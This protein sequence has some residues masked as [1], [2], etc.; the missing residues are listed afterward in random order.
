MPAWSVSVSLRLLDAF[1][2]LQHTLPEAERALRA[3]RASCVGVAALALPFAYALRLDPHLPVDPMPMRWLMTGGAVALLAASFQPWFLARWSCR[4]NLGL[5]YLLVGYFCVLAWANEF[6]YGFSVGTLF[7]FAAAGLAQGLAYSNLAVYARYL[8]VT[9]GMVLLATACSPDFGTHEAVLGLSTASLAALLY[10]TVQ[11]RVELLGDLAQSESHL[12]EAQEAA[13][14]GSWEMDFQTGQIRGP[15]A[16]TTSR[17]STPGPFPARRPSSRS[18]TRTMP[19]RCP[20]GCASTTRS[21][22]A[23]FRAGSAAWRHAE[24]RRA[25]VHDADGR[26]GRSSAPS[27]TQLTRTRARRR[28]DAARP[29]RGR[30]RRQERVPGQHE[31]RDPHAADGHH[32]L[33]PSCSPSETDRGQRD[34]VDPSWPP[35]GACWRRST[36]SSTSPGWRPAT[37]TSPSSRGLR[38]AEAQ[39]VVQL[40]ALA[41]PRRPRAPRADAR[42]PGG[43]SATRAASA[44]CS[45]TSSPTPSSSPPTGASSRVTVP[46]CA[47]SACDRGARTPGA[48]MARSS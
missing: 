20:S 44:A 48:G 5:S 11:A 16:C 36:P 39:A 8:L 37:A 29:R 33:S 17:A 18:S 42:P 24:I 12:A 2:P 31:P 28:S 27:S 15:P 23:T 34:L 7:V 19:R 14:M 45:P 3:F 46:R 10:F 41:R 22:C 38:R 1:N 30:R 47:G 4:I 26:V 40:L 6:V 25:L 21:P 9:T 13:G 35:A 32:R 43:V